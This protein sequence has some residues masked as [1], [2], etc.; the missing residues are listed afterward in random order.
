MWTYPSSKTEYRGNEGFS[1][2]IYLRNT[3][4]KAW[5]P[6]YQLKLVRHIGPEEVT[7]QSSAKLK[8]T[9]PP[10]GAVEFDLWAFGSETPGKQTYIFKLFTV[11]GFPVT[12]SEA[13]ISFTSIQ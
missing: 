3:G 8:V 6:G 12:G 4:S 1:I 9:V 11:Y 2:A 7:V 10:A 13:S 5:E